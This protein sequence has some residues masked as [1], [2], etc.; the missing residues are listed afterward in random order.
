MFRKFLLGAIPTLVA[1][2][3]LMTLT[4]P[5]RAGVSLQ[6]V[7]PTLVKVTKPGSQ[8]HK[9]ASPKIHSAHINQQPKPSNGQNAN[10]YHT[11][12]A[13]WGYGHYG[14]RGYG[15]YGYYRGYYGYR[16][17]RGYRGYYATDAGNDE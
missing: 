11:S 12:Q 10:G 8:S 7:K 13:D 14:Y 4:A 17:Y 15:Y 3:G 1:G 6:L 5:Q 16:S 2:I 9:V